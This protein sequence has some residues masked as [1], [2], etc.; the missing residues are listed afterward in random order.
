MAKLYFLPRTLLKDRDRLLRLG[1]RVEAWL[2]DAFLALLRLLPRRTAEA[3]ARRAFALLG[4]RTGIQTKLLRNLAVLHPDEGLRSL[5]RRSRRTFADLGASVAELAHLRTI[6]SERERLV[7][8]DTDPAVEPVLRDPRAPAVLVT[9]HV[10]PWTLTNLIAG[11]YGFRLTSLYVPES[12]PFVGARIQALRDALPMRFIERDNAMR[13]LLRELG[14]GHKVGLASDVRLDSGEPV[15]FCGHPMLVNTVP[16]RLAL[17][18]GGPLVP[19][20]AERLPGGRFRVIAEAPIE[21]DDPDAPLE[22][23]VQDMAAKLMARYEAWIR[24]WPEEWMCMARRWPKEI[25]LA[26]YERARERG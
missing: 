23:R 1:W 14:A 11:H 20:V 16:V 15:P 12:N 6:A 22:D 2:V 3:F 8:F 7:E 24:R 26:A 19:T 5:K 4:P 10:G 9:A 13:P 21:P 25:E 18:S 17:R